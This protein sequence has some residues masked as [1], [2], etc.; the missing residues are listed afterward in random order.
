VKHVG[1]GMRGSWDGGGEQGFGEGISNGA[2]G[3]ILG[4]VMLFWIGLAWGELR[5]EW[6]DG[7]S[8][9]SR[10]WR[11]WLW[12]SVGVELKK[13]EL[14]FSVGVFGLG[15]AWV[16]LGLVCSLM[17][18]GWALECGIWGGVV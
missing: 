17:G 12:R 14:G 2:V 4:L 5:C 3:G 18:W 7:L 15:W 8:W 10:G 16:G 1:S 11:R 6:V 9:Q 13:R